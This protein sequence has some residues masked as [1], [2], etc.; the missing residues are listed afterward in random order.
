[1]RRCWAWCL[2]R[3]RPGPGASARAQCPSRALPLPREWLHGESLEQ[4]AWARGVGAEASA[5]ARLAQMRE[6]VMALQQKSFCEI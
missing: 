6:S 2:V 3:A 5:P 1:M 4:Q